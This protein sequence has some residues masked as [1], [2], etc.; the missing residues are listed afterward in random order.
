MEQLS[1]IVKLLDFPN[2]IFNFE[3]IIKDNIT[4]LIE[5]NPR[6]SGNYIWQLLGYNYDIDILKVLVQFYLNENNYLPIMKKNNNKYAYQIFYSDTC[7]EYKGVGFKQ[8]ME[9][10]IKKTIE[11]KEYN[12]PINPYNNLYDRAAL[13]LLEMTNKEEELLYLNNINQFKL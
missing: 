11:F 5:I 12:E 2:G 3:A 13:S 7:K 1:K 9:N 8:N 10:I 4:Y 6:P